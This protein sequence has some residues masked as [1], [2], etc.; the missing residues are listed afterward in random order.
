MLHLSAFPG[1]LFGDA[2]DHL[3]NRWVLKVGS[4]EKCHRAEDSSRT[5]AS[6]RDTNY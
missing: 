3:I 2:L 1:V 6:I 4:K 5:A